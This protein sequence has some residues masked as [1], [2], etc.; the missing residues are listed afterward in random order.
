MFE[1]TLLDRL[2]GWIVCTACLRIRMS[3][4]HGVFRAVGLC[5]GD[6]GTR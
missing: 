5:P 6:R 4:V 3:P 1:A 2:C